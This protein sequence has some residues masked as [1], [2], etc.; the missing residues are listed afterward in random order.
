M[1]HWLGQKISE[2]TSQR[3]N[4]WTII[5]N[6]LCL[7]PLESNS[8]LPLNFWCFRDNRLCGWWSQLIFE[9]IN[10]QGI[11]CSNWS[12][13]LPSWDQTAH[14]PSNCTGILI[15]VSLLLLLTLWSVWQVNSQKPCLKNLFENHS[16]SKIQQKN[17]LISELYYT[18]G[19][20]KCR[21]NSLFPVLES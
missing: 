15:F 13:F 11:R 17:P 6:N 19:D 16:T 2:S 20:V 12:L 7:V 8:H 14:I 4:P 5:Y 18:S 1:Q 10:G 9:S 3:R 21:W